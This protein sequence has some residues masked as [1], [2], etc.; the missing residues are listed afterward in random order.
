MGELINRF[1]E[2]IDSD[3]ARQNFGDMTEAEEP[4]WIGRPTVLS[5]LERYLLIGLVFLTHIVFFW[6]ATGDD[7]DGEGRTNFVIGL[8]K[9]VL[10]ISGVSGFVLMMLVIAKLNHYLNFST[11][12]RW[13]TSWL[14]I[15][16]FVPL[17][18]VIA[19]W[20]GKLLG[21]IFGELP[22]T[23]QWLDMY[24]LVLGFASCGLASILTISYQRAFMYAITDRRIHIRKQFLYLDTSIHGISFSDI[25]NLKATPSIIG[26]LFGFGDLFLITASGIGLEPNSDSVGA[27]NG[28]TID[29]DN[30]T[31]SPRGYFSL[32]FGWISLQ[33]SR[34]NPLNDPEGCLYGISDPMTIYQLINEL[35]DS[36]VGPAGI[37][38]PELDTE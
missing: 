17:L 35:M 24:Y 9:A 30:Q 13:T 6:A 37:I 28:L 8:A 33:R 15:N 11:S 32:L 29:N 31:T 7:L 23:P 3:Q 1:R 5:M 26:R 12:G 25:E 18:V 19:D 38:H 4:I 21:I 27:T 14:V 36:N 22:D 16:S 10:D 34:S 20:S 2:E